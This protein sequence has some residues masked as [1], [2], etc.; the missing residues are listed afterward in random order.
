VTFVA[1]S[2]ALANHAADGC[3]WSWCGS[4]SLHVYY[5]SPICHTTESRSHFGMAI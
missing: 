5:G 3:R 4:K 2:P 1:I